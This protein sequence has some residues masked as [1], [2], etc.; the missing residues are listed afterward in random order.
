VSGRETGKG[1]REERVE[2]AKLT[3]KPRNKERGGAG[4]MLE[5]STRPVCGP[6]TGGVS[7]VRV[8]E[9]EQ[10]MAAAYILL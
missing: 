8:K 1:G 9:F 6:A 2:P 5:P 4:E 10:E 7:N 3:S